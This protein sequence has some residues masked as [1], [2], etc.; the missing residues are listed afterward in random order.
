M[1]IDQADLLDGMDFIFVQKFM[2]ITTRER[3]PEGYIVL[4]QGDKADYF[5][6]L[7]EGCVRLT[8]SDP[9]KETYV[10]SH[11]GEAFG[12]S[13]LLD[14]NYYS[15]SAECLQ[16]THL[17]KIE[18]SA[19]A[20]LLAAHPEHSGTFYKRIAGMLAHRLVECYKLI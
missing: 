5:Y 10:V 11:P 3:H 12:W 9:P 13:S 18:R 14:R 19:L 17:H 8:A 15:A 7:I 4:R 6:T 20:A 1:L 16:P 2:A